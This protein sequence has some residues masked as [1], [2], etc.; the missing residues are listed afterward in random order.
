MDNSQRCSSSIKALAED[1]K[2]LGKSRLYATSGRDMLN[3]SQKDRLQNCIEGWAEELERLSEAV[4]QCAV[5]TET[6]GAIIYRKVE[7]IIVK[8]HAAG[9]MPNGALVS[10]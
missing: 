2:A 1:F 5:E 6:D 8:A 3:E 4:L 7:A 10:E 9:V